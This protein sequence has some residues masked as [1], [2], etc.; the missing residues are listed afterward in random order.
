MKK[1]LFIVLIV[2]VIGG[3]GF[4]F[5]TLPS[6]PQQKQVDAYVEMAESFA[7][8]AEEAID[9]GDDE[10]AREYLDSAEKYKVKA[11]VLLRSISRNQ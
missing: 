6:T 3:I 5:L 1:L 10:M 4:Y 9:L 11:D 8:L 7:E 2:L